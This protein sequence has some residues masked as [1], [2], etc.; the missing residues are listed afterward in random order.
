[1]RR[2]IYA[3]R[4]R[5]AD[6]RDFFDN[7]EVYEKTFEL[8]WENSGLE[9]FLKAPEEARH[10]RAVLWEFFPDIVRTFEHFTAIKHHLK[11]NE[12]FCMRASRLALWPSCRVLSVGTEAQ[13]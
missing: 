4:E 9:T 10:V 2:S 3:P 5:E 6:S 1:M 11:S 13:L 12:V 7:M 8:E